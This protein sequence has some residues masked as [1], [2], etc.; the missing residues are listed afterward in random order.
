LIELNK[1]TPEAVENA[2]RYWLSTAYMA[3]GMV[4]LACLMAISFR[5]VIIQKMEAWADARH[6]AMESDGQMN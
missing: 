5:R 1:K 2:G 3:F 6:E 4:W